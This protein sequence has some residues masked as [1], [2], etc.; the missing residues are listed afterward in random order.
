MA[1]SQAK[2]VQSFP[3]SSEAINFQEQTLKF[4][5]KT[6]AD[7]IE[8]PCYQNGH[9]TTREHSRKRKQ[10]Q[11]TEGQALQDQCEPIEKRRRVSSPAR[12]NIA[13]ENTRDCSSKRLANIEYWA[14]T[15]EWPA[16]LFEPG[17]NMSQQLRKRR[18]SSD[19][20]Y[21]QSVKEGIN[22]PAHSPEYER[23]ILDAAGVILE[24]Q[25]GNAAI[26][27]D[28]EKLCTTLLSATYNPPENSFFEGDLFWKVMGSIRGRNEPRVV[29]DIGL[30]I[31]PSAEHLKLRGIS[32][33]AYL[34]EEVDT[35]WRRCASIAGPMPKPD[36]T[37]GLNLNEFTDDEIKE[38]NNYSTFLKSTE[39]IESL[40]FPFS[41]ARRK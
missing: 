32:K 36:L 27:T 12:D 38:F 10:S 25:F 9:E 18:S 6:K 28:C 33:I 14:A 23:K 24:Y 29:R 2:V 31:A 22:L 34:R 3:P 40:C 8:E 5:P 7:K 41:L 26:T 37:V 39:V 11:S 20:S 35:L 30:C 21:T 1:R 15:G 19:M 16:T 13:K 17:H 4:S